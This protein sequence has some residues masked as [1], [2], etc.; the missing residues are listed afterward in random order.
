MSSLPNIDQP[1]SKAEHINRHDA[2][3]NTASQS[4]HERDTTSEFSHPKDSE[5]TKLCTFLDDRAYDD[6]SSVTFQDEFLW[7]QV[8]VNKY[9]QKI[10]S[11]IVPALLQGF[12]NVSPSRSPL[13]EFELEDIFREADEDSSNPG[14]G[15]PRY[16]ATQK[17]KW[18]AQADGDVM[19][20]SSGVV[21]PP[22]PQ[23][24]FRSIFDIAENWVMHTRPILQDYADRQTSL[25]LGRRLEVTIDEPPKFILGA[26]QLLV[27]RD[28]KGCAGRSG[29]LGPQLIE[30]FVDIDR[31]AKEYFRSRHD[32]QV[33][34]SDVPALL[35]IVINNFYEGQVQLIDRLVEFALEN[36]HFCGRSSLNVEDFA[37]GF[38][39]KMSQ[40]LPFYVETSSQIREPLPIPAVEVRPTTPEPVITHSGRQVKPTKRAQAASEQAHA[41]ANGRRNK[42]NNS[43]QLNNKEAAKSSA[44]ARQKKSSTQPSAQRTVKEIPVPSH[45]ESDMATPDPPKTTS[46]RTKPRPTRPSNLGL[47]PILP[48]SSSTP[49]ITSSHSNDSS[50]PEPSASGAADSPKGSGSKGVNPAIDPPL[51]LKIRLPAPSLPT[52]TVSAARGSESTISKTSSPTAQT[53][54]SADAAETTKKERVARRPGV[55]RPRGPRNGRGRGRGR[56]R[57]SASVIPSTGSSTALL[58]A[59]DRS[60]GTGDDDPSTSQ[61][62]PTSPPLAADPGHPQ[63]K[64]RKLEDCDD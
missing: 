30:N 19:Q 5:S 40:D 63:R 49:G 28:Q 35:T 6:A 44:P 29:R 54:P 60:T 38:D 31:W 52:S 56:E 12:R 4:V 32:L 36:M 3:L 37:F 59:A 33:V 43:S 15:V 13:D 42:G 64:K 24:Q 26:V 2:N 51:R 45:A 10:P 39:F 21:K 20:S 17:G 23:F 34:D 47:P 62:T 48:I 18:K 50:K 9:S 46:G 1:A 57:E 58:H 14:D 27:N 11:M 7:H 53:N 8:G 55:A 41:N 25:P 22:S 61:N 16:S